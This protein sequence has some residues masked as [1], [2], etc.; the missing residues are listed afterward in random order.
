MDLID[1]EEQPVKRKVGLFLFLGI[2]HFPTVVTWY[3][4]RKGFSRRARIAAFSY[5]SVIWVGFSLL[6]LNAPED[7]SVKAED[8]RAYQNWAK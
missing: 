2:I 5:M 7:F 6:I 4:L 1:E 3:L 8:S